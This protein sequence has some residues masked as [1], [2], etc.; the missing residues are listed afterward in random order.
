LVRR[1]R[2]CLGSIGNL[3]PVGMKMATEIEKELGRERLIATVGD[4]VAFLKTYQEVALKKSYYLLE[5]ETFL[6]LEK[7]LG[8]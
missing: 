3:A 4:T 8:I 7:L 1:L 5:D 6:I 2:K